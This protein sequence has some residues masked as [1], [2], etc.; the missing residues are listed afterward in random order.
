VFAYGSGAFPTGT[1][2]SSNYWVDVV[3]QDTGGPTL[4]DRSPA[5]GATG[6]DPAVTPSATFSEGVQPATVD[7][8][9]QDSGGAPVAGA[10]AYDANTLTATFTPSS[11]LGAGAT[12]TA[13][14]RGARD[15]FGNEMADP[16]IWSFTTSGAQGVSL[17][18]N[19]TPATP[20]AN[21][22]GSVEVGTR[23]RTT[24]SGSALGV[25]FFKGPGNTGTHVGN[26][27]TASGALLATV[28]FSGESSLGW[29][30]AA[31][32]SPIPLTAGE[33][34]VVSYHAPA[35]RY[36]VNGGFFAAG[37]VVSGPLV[38]VG[39]GTGNLNGVYRYGSGGVFPTGSYNSANYW[40]DVLFASSGS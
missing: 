36:S 27:W 10:I 31:F 1:Y 21:D 14:V 2:G 19:Q 13:S 37:D 32:S 6:V 22:P 33:T 30:Y 28:T 8:R 34:Y 12:Y 15:V 24:E 23:F 11:P 25:R 4:T 3:F 40:V 26:L 35:G 17:F 29:Q 38:G 5:P 16:V 20:A 39:N 9:L 7:F 18:G